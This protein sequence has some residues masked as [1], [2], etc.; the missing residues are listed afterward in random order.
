MSKRWPFSLLND[1]QMS[2]WVGVKHLTIRILSGRDIFR[3]I[4][5]VLGFPKSDQKDVGQ[6]LN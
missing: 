5:L 4:Q 6:H 2:N 3:Q 1:E